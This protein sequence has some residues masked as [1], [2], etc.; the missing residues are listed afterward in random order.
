MSKNSS[1]DFPWL[2]EELVKLVA[3]TSA[4]QKAEAI[5]AQSMQSMKD[6]YNRLSRKVDDMGVD[7]SS[8]KATVDELSLTKHE[9]NV[10]QSMNNSKNSTNS[11]LIGVIILGIVAVVFNAVMR[12]SSKGIEVNTPT[13]ITAPE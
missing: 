12:Y 4:L 11:I 10:N 5:T 8:I 2:R 1:D 13:E 9:P 6:A 3:S 7:I